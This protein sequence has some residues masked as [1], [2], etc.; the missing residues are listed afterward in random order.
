[1]GYSREV[2]RREGGSEKGRDRGIEIWK[3]ECMEGGRKIGMMDGIG[4][5]GDMDI[6]GKEGRRGWRVKWREDG[7]RDGWLGEM[8]RWRDRERDRR[9]KGGRA[10]EEGGGGRRR[11]EEGG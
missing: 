10:E 8:Y 4:M 3:E 6:E 11:K 2:W 9:M 7:G 1:M 5:K